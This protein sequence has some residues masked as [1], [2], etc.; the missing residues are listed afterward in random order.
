M[1]ELWT[2]PKVLRWPTASTIPIMTR[3]EA[4]AISFRSGGLAAV[5]EVV[6]A[7]AHS[8]QGIIGWVLPPLPEGSNVKRRGLEAT[9]LSFAISDDANDELDD[10]RWS[11]PTDP[12]TPRCFPEAI[13]RSRTEPFSLL[14]RSYACALCSASNRKLR[15]C[16]F[17][18]PLGL[19]EQHV[20]PPACYLLHLLLLLLCSVGVAQ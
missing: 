3:K 9:R 4:A 7:G 5:R 8:H 15:C 12:A 10:G 2:T 19:H 20:P 13:L 6:E 18:S 17:P 11:G 16:G 14:L 1:H